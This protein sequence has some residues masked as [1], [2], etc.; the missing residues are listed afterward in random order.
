MPY[1]D[2]EIYLRVGI[3]NG[4]AVEEKEAVLPI[5]AGEYTSFYGQSLD[6][7]VFVES[8]EEDAA[9]LEFLA[10]HPCSTAYD[11]KVQ[12]LYREQRFQCS[13]SHT[14]EEGATERISFLAAYQTK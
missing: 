5:E 9:I 11:G 10:V 14:T 12:R 1:P 13:F 8:V 2:E 3:R 4:S 6:A 7:H